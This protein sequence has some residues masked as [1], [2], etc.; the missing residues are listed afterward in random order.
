MEGGG[1]GR[2]REEGKVTLATR[3]PVFSK[4]MSG[5]M[6]MIARMKLPE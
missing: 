3:K 2:E 1:G 5:K 4:P 6:L